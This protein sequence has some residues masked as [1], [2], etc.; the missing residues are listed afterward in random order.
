MATT[1]FEKGLELEN[2]FAEYM[3]AE[4]GYDEIKER[5]M[6]KGID[7]SKGVEID[8]V[9]MQYDERSERFRRLAFVTLAI[10]LLGMGASFLEIEPFNSDMIGFFVLIEFIAVGYAIIGR[11]LNTKYTGVECKN[12]K[13]KVNIKLVREFYHQILDNNQSKDK[14]YKLSNMIFVSKNGFVNNALEYAS[15]KGILCYQQ[16]ENGFKKVKY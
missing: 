1:N 4:L 11:M 13:T 12:H 3:I 2:K 5:I 16:V 7:N 9:G 15:N 14:K 8:I 10:A 6:I